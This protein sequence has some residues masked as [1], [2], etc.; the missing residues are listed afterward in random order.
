MMHG[1]M[2]FDKDDQLLVPFRTWRNTITGEASQQLTDLFGYPIPQRWSIA[3]LYQAILNNESHVEDIRFITTLAG[4]VHWKLTGQ[5]YMG[6][7]EASGMFP[8]DIETKLYHTRM[9]KQFDELVSDKK[10]DWDINCILPPVL[11][12]GEQAGK[13]TEYGVKLLD[14]TGKL[15]PGIPMCPP[16]GDAGTGMV[17]TNSITERTGNVSA[18][19]SAFACIVLEKNLSKVYSEI[20]QVT[21]PN[22]KLVAMVHS[23][24]CTSDLNA[25]VSLFDEMLNELGCHVDTN[26]LYETLFRVALKGD[27]DCDGLL[28]YPYISGEHITGLETGCPLF[29]RSSSSNFNLANFMR[30]H[31]Y[32]AIGAM[33]IGLDILFDQEGV[34]VDG[35][36]GHG[37]LFK[38]EGVGQKILASALNTPVTVMKT[39]GEGGAW[40]MATLAAFMICKKTYGT[41]DNFLNE[42]VFASQEKSVIKP[43]EEEV[44]SYNKYIE[45]YKE[46][47]S[48]EREAVNMF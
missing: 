25:W 17:A 13:L 48:I 11:D 9:L 42:K 29:V 1:Y 16:E 30:T 28:S 10:Y 15:R 46:G 44:L 19:T 4:Y 37:G 26:T 33:R 8:I 47:L 43:K 39:A 20:D 7:G 31:L 32:S 22:G 45:Q 35:I 40:G 14:S 27:F 18:G 38:T 24:N 34:C 41:L 3:H 6:V 36:L 23:N 5:K 2:A 21:T 12:A